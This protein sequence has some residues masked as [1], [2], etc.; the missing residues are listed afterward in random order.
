[1]GTRLP[2]DFV[3]FIETYGP[4]EVCGWLNVRSPFS[5]GG[6]GFVARML[7]ALGALRELKASFPE[8]IP[9]PLHFEPGG[10]I[11]WGTSMD[12]DEFCWL[13]QGLP[14]EWPTVIVCRHAPIEEHPLG[15]EAL[16]ESAVE[17]RLE[18][19]AWPEDIGEVTFVPQ[20]D[21]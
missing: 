4:G 15:M 7:A 17:G 13:A 16:L 14:S 9:Y 6:A 2:E 12:G 21:L 3:A 5:S 11:P 10:L 8:T 20:P 19:N 1:V 18:S